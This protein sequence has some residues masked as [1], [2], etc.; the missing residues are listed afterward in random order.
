MIVS[1]INP[2]MKLI[3]LP[4]SNAER[5]PVISVEGLSCTNVSLR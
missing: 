2:Y 4:T 5:L 1:E 3:R